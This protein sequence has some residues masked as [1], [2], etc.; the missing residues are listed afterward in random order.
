MSKSEEEKKGGDK[1]NQGDSS[2]GDALFS[3]GIVGIESLIS[4]ISKS[5]TQKT[6]KIDRGNSFIL[7]EYGSESFY[8]Y[9]MHSW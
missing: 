7:I 4:E 3:G 9:S 6:N 5:E 1:L 2:S 8:R